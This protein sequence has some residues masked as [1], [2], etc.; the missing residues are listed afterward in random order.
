MAASFTDPNRGFLLPAGPGAFMCEI[1]GG[2]DKS[3]GGSH[4]MW[5]VART[6]LDANAL[7]DDQIPIA[8]DAGD[9]DARMGEGFLSSIWNPGS[10]AGSAMRAGKAVVSIRWAQP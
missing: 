5:A 10:G 9:G 4:A 7:H 6:W 8:V 2:R 1:F 3:L